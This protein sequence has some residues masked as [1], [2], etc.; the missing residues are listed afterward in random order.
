MDIQILFN[1]LLEQQLLLSIVFASFILCERFSLKFLGASFVYKLIW[2]IPI[3]LLVAN[4]PSTIKPL[5]NSSISYYLTSPNQPFINSVSF[6]WALFYVLVT[7]LLLSVAFIV[8][9]RFIKT[10]Q[11]K[12][13]I[14]EVNMTSQINTY[15]S[16]HIATPMVIGILQSKLV[17]PNNYAKLFDKEALALILEHEHVHIKR[18]DNLINALLLFGTILLWFNPL[19]WMAYASCR[20]LQELTCDQQV[21]ANKTIQQHILYSKALVNCAATTPAGLIA[22]SHYGDKKMML[23]RLANIKYS[24]NNSRF[25]K[26]ACL[27]V[28][29]SMLGTLAIAK[30]P[31]NEV[32]EKAHISPTMRIEPLYPI[33][34]AQQGI[35]GSVVLKYDITPS[36][37]TTN[38]SVVKAKP[39]ATFDKEAKKALQQWQYKPSS[40]G[41]Q[42]VLVQLDFV[43]NSDVES[44]NLIE[45]VKVSH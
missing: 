18:K 27:L 15:T 14:G 29:T 1:W 40:I 5:Q 6:N 2:L 32:S 33:Q 16:E 34:A 39:E 41:Y 9:T 42:D 19:A 44:S 31:Q 38:I 10:L 3:S 22:Y 36:G 8:H 4:L 11:L 20:R 26:G 24:S 17:L 23:Q 28:A 35:S 37:N 21:L 43:I 45:R 25:A 7:M 13:L 12:N 30:Q